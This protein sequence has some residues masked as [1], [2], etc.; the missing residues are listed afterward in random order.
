MLPI[1]HPAYLHIRPLD[2]GMVDKRTPMSDTST[3]MVVVELFPG[4][5][6]TTEALLRQGVRIQ[7]VY[8][9]ER[10]ARSRLIDARRLALLYTTYAEQ[11]SENALRECHSHLPAHP[12]QITWGHVATMV[13]PDV[14]VASFPSNGFSY[15]LE[16][17]SQGM[18]DARTLR[19]LEE[20]IKII[21]LIN[22]LWPGS[23]CAYLFE[24]IDATNHPQ[25][26]VRD[27]FNNVVKGI[28][29]LGVSF[30]PLA[31]SSD[32]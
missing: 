26:N 4:L 14:V 15:T 9:C 19:I 20:A 8:A 29:G 12:I 22:S 2:V 17:A 23:P 6:A 24:T 16:K 32:T 25:E 11:L 1:A 3:G 10:D 13:K 30:E 7:K 18:R 31:I 5:T 21:Q 27:E 28:L